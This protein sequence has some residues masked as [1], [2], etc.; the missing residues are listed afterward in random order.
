MG[1]IVVRSIS[2]RGFRP[3]SILIWY[4]SAPRGSHNNCQCLFILYHSWEWVLSKRVLVSLFLL[5]T[6]YSN[7]LLATFV[8]VMLQLRIVMLTQH[9]R[10]NLRQVMAQAWKDGPSVELSTFRDTEPKA[11]TGVHSSSQGT[12]D[13][14]CLLLLFSCH[15]NNLVTGLSVNTRLRLLRVRRLGVRFQSPFMCTV[16]MRVSQLWTLPTAML[17]SLG[18]PCAAQ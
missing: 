10:L 2:Y 4:P 14:V 5:H 18:R 11:S 7:A 3:V 15:W 8:H 13:P 12:R 17:W 9:C 6:V 16:L 1:L